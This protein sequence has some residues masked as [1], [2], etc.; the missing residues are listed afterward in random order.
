MHTLDAALDTAGTHILDALER[1]ELA[2]LALEPHKGTDAADR[3]IAD[4]TNA[5]HSLAFGAQAVA[6]REHAAAEAQ[7]RAWGFA[8]DGVGESWFDGRVVI[9]VRP[10]DPGADWALYPADGDEGCRP[11]FT[12]ATLARMVELVGQARAMFEPA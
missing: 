4:L 6:H 3:W 7:L 9:T 12:A 2:T 10:T 11:M 5:R 8:L 1:L